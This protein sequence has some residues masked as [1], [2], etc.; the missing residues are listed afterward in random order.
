[1]LAKNATGVMQSVIVITAFVVF[2]IAMSGVTVL[3]NLASMRFSGDEDAGLY[4]SVHQ[5]ATGIRGLF[6]PFFGYFIMEQFGK[7]AAFLTAAGFW[8]I[9][10]LGMVG[11]RIWDKKAGKM[12]SLRVVKE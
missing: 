6:A 12:Y 9:A 2:G 1:M 3:W 8:I 5:A 7:N 11:A 4:Q 10:A